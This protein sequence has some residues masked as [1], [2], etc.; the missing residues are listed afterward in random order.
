MTSASPLDIRWIERTATFQRWLAQNPAAVPQVLHESREATIWVLPTGAAPVYV[1]KRW[2]PGR[3]VDARAN[4]RLLHSL[5]SLGLPAVAPV[6]WGYD[7]EDGQLLAM[8]Y[9]GHPVDRASQVDI[10]AF[11]RTLGSIH[12]APLDQLDLAPPADSSVFFDRLRERFF[13]GVEAFEDLTALLHQARRQLPS[14]ETVLIHGDY[15]LGNVARGAAGLS[16]LDWSE[17]Q[18]GDWRYDLAWAELLTLIYTGPRAQDIFM[19]AYVSASGRSLRQGLRPYEIV[20]A[21][22][23]LLL[24]RTAP[25]PVPVAWQQTVEAFLQSRLPNP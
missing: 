14:L 12:A 5:G 11:G 25:F 3:W 10:E 20:A 8:Q 2:T 15:H 24:S 4:Y 13:D 21:I 23:W 9:A 1:I 17:A 22:R 16:V 19:E 6:G 7:G 18:L